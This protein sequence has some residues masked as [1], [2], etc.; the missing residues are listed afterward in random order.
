[1]SEEWDKY[2]SATEK[3]LLGAAGE[4]ADKEEVKEFFKEQALLFGK[5]F[6]W[7]EAAS[8]PAEKQEHEDNI[9]A[10]LGQS[11]AELRRLVIA[12]DNTVRARL[13]GILEGVGNLILNIVKGQVG[14]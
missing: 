4:F 12:A 1:M 9:A 11:K 2:V 5:E 3:A 6:Y 13:E 10:N 14:A 8:D 7:A